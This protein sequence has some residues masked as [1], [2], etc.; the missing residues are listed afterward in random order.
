MFVS[1]LKEIRIWYMEAS[2]ASINTMLAKATRLVTFDSYKLWIVGG[3]SIFR[4]GFDPRRDTPLRFAS[5]DLKSLRLHRSDT[6]CGLEVWAPRL[7]RL[8]LQACY[9]LDFVKVLA[10]HPLR[11]AL[12]DG[13]AFS[14]FTV[15]LVNASQEAIP[16]LL[17]TGRVDGFDPDE[18]EW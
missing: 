1:G 5:N 9:D 7:E 17:A 11:A 14:R 15:R 13:T 6:L 8:N 18:Q 10:D 2:L 4:G 16:M 12:P 3:P